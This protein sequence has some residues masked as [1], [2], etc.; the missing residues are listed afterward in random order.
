MRFGPE[1]LAARL[2]PL[3]AAAGP[4]ALAVA[5]SGG[6]DSAALLHA[7]AAL[8]RAEPR[9]RVRALH[10]N[11]GLQPAAAGLEAAARA[12]AAAAG[13]DV[14][15]LEVAVAAAD[16]AGLEAAARAARY[17][18]L[19]GA[20]A[21][22]EALLTAH[23]RE[24]QAETLL[25]QLVRG[26]G[27]R[28]L[29]AMPAGVLRGSHALLRPLLEVPRAALLD[30]AREHGLTWFEDPMNAD[31]RYDRAWLRSGLWPTLV[32][33]WPAA[34]LTL[35]RAAAHLAEAQALLDEHAAEDLARVASGPALAVAPLLALSP[36]RRAALLRYWL[37]R[38]RGLRAPAARRLA[39]IERELLRAR[40]ANAPRMAWQGAEL[41][42]YAGCL[43]AFAPLPP[44]PWPRRL[45]L[46][47][48]GGAGVA[49][50]TLE[51]GRLG[52]LELTRGVGEGIAAT[53]CAGALELRAR[54]GGERLQR[55]TGGSRHEL[56]ELL[57]EARVPPW[58]RARVAL[59]YADEE[60]LAVVLPGA[61]WIEAR[62]AAG[63]GEPGVA[64][65]WCAAPAELVA[66]PPGAAPAGVR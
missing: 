29:A 50:A 47:A 12:A 31:P 58:T 39:L 11:H 66:A 36:A 48:P 44:A 23:H 56:K 25:L 55:T 45:P 22:A 14:T 30:Y 19:F 57:R 24:D 54:A 17:A 4:V 51:L 33:R 46:V 28:G 38:E 41:R 52:R 3:C 6:A 21:P 65:R 42:R 5:A 60:L 27:L 34:P 40:G 18:A 49:P 15:V 10:V 20:L 59:V 43:Y 8:A 13:L 53:R 63:P 9:Y 35:A 37:V 16:P 7:C 61:T 64:I 2:A 62:A 26:A 32:A 1:L